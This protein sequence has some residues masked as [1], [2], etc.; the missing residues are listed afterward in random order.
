MGLLEKRDHSKQINSAG[1]IVAS[2][3]VNLLILH[4]RLRGGNFSSY[5]RVRKKKRSSLQATPLSEGGAGGA[6]TRN[7]SQAMEKDSSRGTFPTRDARG[8][9]GNN[10]SAQKGG[11]YHV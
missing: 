5:F 10:Y 1:V 7:T 9:E 2:A 8:A 3:R 6:F 11:E 4:A